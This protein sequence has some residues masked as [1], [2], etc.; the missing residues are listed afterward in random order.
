[1]REHAHAE[2]DSRHAG[3]NGASPVETAR[4]LGLRRGHGQSASL[5]THALE[6]RTLP[7]DRPSEAQPDRSLGERTTAELA[8][9]GQYRFE[10]LRRILGRR[11]F[12]GRARGA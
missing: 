4:L 5:V 7:E 12:A 1:R 6:R 8:R 2:V 10:K 3:G 11:Y 9:A